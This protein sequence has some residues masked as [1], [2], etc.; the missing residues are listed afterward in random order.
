[1]AIYATM[2]ERQRAIANQGAPAGIPVSTS[3]YGWGRALRLTPALAALLLTLAMFGGASCGKSIFPEVTNSSS[4]TATATITVSPTVGPYLYSSNNGDGKAG[5]FKRNTTT[6]ALSLIGSVAAGSA[7]GPIGIANGPGAKY[8]YVA[9][10]VDGKIQQYKVT[11]SSGKLASIGTIATGSQP[12]WIAVNPTGAYAFATN[13]GAGT[14]S[15]YTISST[16]GVLASNGGAFS[17]VLLSKPQGAVATNSYLFVADSA[18]GSVSSFPIGASGTLSAGTTAIVGN[19]PGV[20]FPTDLVLDPFTNAAFQQ[21]YLYASDPTTGFVYSIGYN[22]A[23]GAPAYLNPYPSSIA[24]LGGMAIVQLSA[25]EFLYAANQKVSPPSLTAFIV[26]SGVLTFSA[27][28]SDPSLNQP[29]GIAIGPN[30]NNLYVANQGTGTITQFSINQSTGAL[31]FVKV[32]NTESATSAPLYLT[33][34]D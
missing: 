32:V 13:Q 5:E 26:N 25:G 10:S 2:D 3:I 28:Y 16:T 34:T 17:S 7:G 18:N 6:G 11:A 1:M 24:G 27:T 33:I 29:T 9:N 12:Q 8:V 15:Q 31:T 23:N 19:G 21:G 30:K 20:S 14:I 22:L 4:P